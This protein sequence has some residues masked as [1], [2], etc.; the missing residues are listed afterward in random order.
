MQCLHGMCKKD[1]TC[2]NKCYAMQ[3]SSRAPRNSCPESVVS[4]IYQFRSAI[5]CRHAWQGCHL[6]HIDCI[7]DLRSIAVGRIL[8]V[9]YNYQQQHSIVEVLYTL[10]MRSGFALDSPLPCASRYSST[11]K[12]ARPS[13]N[14]LH[15]YRAQFLFAVWATG[16]LRIGARAVFGVGVDVIVFGLW[17][18]PLRS[19]RQDIPWARKDMMHS[20]LLHAG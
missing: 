7:M 14:R 2:A 12:S 16:Q 19:L 9:S 20:S 5:F 18:H 3:L 8:V 11:G 13:S 4:C 1:R 6:Q 17:W 10:L 15:S